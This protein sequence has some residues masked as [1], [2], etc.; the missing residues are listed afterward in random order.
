MC[1]RRPHT[2]A[3]PE[4]PLCLLIRDG[5]PR[6]IPALLAHEGVPVL[7]ARSDPARRPRAVGPEQRDAPDLAEA[8][9]ARFCDRGAT[10]LT[11][12]ILPTP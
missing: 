1:C 5:F 3:P 6:E 11:L 2:L 10:A 9:S 4:G 12:C 8:D 7:S